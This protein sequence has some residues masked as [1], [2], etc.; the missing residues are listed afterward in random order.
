MVVIYNR[1]DTETQTSPVPIFLMLFSV[2]VRMLYSMDCFPY[3]VVLSDLASVNS[4]QLKQKDG[5]SRSFSKRSVFLTVMSSSLTYYSDYNVQM[6]KCKGKKVIEINK[7]KPHKNQ[8][9]L[10]VCS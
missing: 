7:Q 6:I 2:S 9:S 1:V 8:I 3:P 5:V 4:Y 10:H